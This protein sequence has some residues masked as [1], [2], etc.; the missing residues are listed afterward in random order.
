M[1]WRVQ[2]KKK[3]EETKYLRGAEQ[4]LY[5]EKQKMEK[6]LGM[7]KQ[8]LKNMKSSGETVIVKTR[9]DSFQFYL[10]EADEILKYLPVKEKERVTGIVKAEYY[11]KLK[12][13]LEKRI[14]IINR[15]I[16]G[17]KETDPSQV[18]EMMGKGKQKLIEPFTL[19]DKQFRVEWEKC[20]Y[21]GKEYWDDSVEIYT[22]KG[23]RVRSKS[24]K[25][26]ADKLYKEDI[27]YRYEYP[28]E[29]PGVGIIYPDFT[30]L[31]LRKRR[32]IILEHFGL[33]DNEDYAN[34]AVSKIQLYAKEGYVLGDNFFC[35]M[36]TMTKP[37]DSRVLDGIIGQ[38]RG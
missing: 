24:E 13:K 1:S 32:N 38:I 26:I 18:F 33:M 16:S 36:E 10:R 31:D 27:A 2:K 14:K 21:C 11:N 5:E 29:I 6:L 3:R 34:N 19:T 4:E 7:L 9:G 35:T 15:C 30:I 20:E 23:E 28:L 17:L 25:I 12:I 22:D 37:L 8:E